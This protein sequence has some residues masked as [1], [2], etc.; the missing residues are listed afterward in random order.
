MGLLPGAMMTPAMTV[1]H[2]M[3]VCFFNE[4]DPGFLPARLSNFVHIHCQRNVKIV[5]KMTTTVHF[6]MKKID[7][8][9]VPCRQ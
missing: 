1:G 9:F 6:N 5:M 7:K 3:S 8:Y 4:N 2:N